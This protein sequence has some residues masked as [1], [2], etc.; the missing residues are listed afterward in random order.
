VLSNDRK[1]L[2]ISLDPAH[3]RDVSSVML[4]RRTAIT[5]LVDGGQRGVLLPFT[6]DGKT[7]HATLPNDASVLPPGPYLVFVNAKAQKGNKPNQSTP[8][9]AA[10]LTIGDTG[11][12]ST[13][14]PLHTSRT[15]AKSVTP[16]LARAGAVPVDANLAFHEIAHVAGA[17]PVPARPASDRIPWPVWPALAAVVTTALWA[18][19][20]RRLSLR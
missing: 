14:G 19:R 9:V 2:E 18:M 15:A 1:N 3:N 6:Q 5:H 11:Q 4:M 10:E 20:L 7:I 16:D 8:S 17:L 12:P 13:S